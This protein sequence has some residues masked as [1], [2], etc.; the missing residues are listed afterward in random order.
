MNTTFEIHVT[1]CPNN[2]ANMFLKLKYKSTAREN[3]N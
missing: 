2:N 3:T 1:N